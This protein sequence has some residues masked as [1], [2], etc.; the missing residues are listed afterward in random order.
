MVNASKILT[1]SYGTFSCTLEGFDEPFS[2]MKSI[3]EY[4]RDLAADDR[5]FGAEPPTPDAEMLHRIAEREIQRRVEARV[6]R[7]GILLRPAED[8]ETDDSEQSQQVDE[9]DTP[10][11]A[12]DPMVAATV[13]TSV[14]ARADM[15]PEAPDAPEA[16]ADPT[17]APAPAAAAPAPAPAAP[18]EPADPHAETVAEK[19]RRIRAA[20]ARAQTEPQ[21]ASTFAE[22]ER[23]ELSN[24]PIDGIMSAP[25]EDE[26]EDEDVPAADESA[27]D[28]EGML[29]AVAAAELG[30]VPATVATDED[31]A[32]EDTVEDTAEQASPE[33]A[34]TEQAADD[35]D[36]AD[37]AALGLEAEADVPFEFAA[38]T[39]ADV[40]DFAE[41]SSFEDETAEDTLA[42]FEMPEDDG[43]ED[44]A[45]DMTAPTDM[46]DI[47]EAFAA[48]DFEDE[49]EDIALVLPET[50]GV[51]R[52]EPVAETPADDASF[53]D[54]G[55]DIESLDLDTSA[56]ET[57]EDDADEAAF[58]ETAEDDLSD[59]D[60]GDILG[61][62]TASEPEA[63]EETAPVE[64]DTAE[65]VSEETDEA[66]DRLPP[67]SLTSA[68][69]IDETDEAEADDAPHVRVLKM[70]RDEFD[71]QYA[72][73][74]TDEDTEV[75]ELTSLD[76]D[77]EPLSERDEIRAALGETGLSEDDEADLIDELMRAGQD[78]EETPDTADIDHRDAVAA[79]LA[80]AAA[81]VQRNEDGDTTAPDTQSGDVPVDRL[82]A[83][84][85]T[86]LRNNDNKRRRSAIAHLKAAVAAVR[87]DGGRAASKREREA[88]RAMSQYR[89][90]LASAVRPTSGPALTD[91]DARSHKLRLDDATEDMGDT[92]EAEAEA[93]TP[94]PAPEPAA[95]RPSGLRR[96]T[97]SGSGDQPRRKRP[98]APL[99]LVSE[100]RI[101]REED[102]AAE[103]SARPVRPRRVRS[104][105]V[106]ASE[107]ASQ[108]DVSEDG[109]K[110]FVDRMAPDGLQELLEASA[111]FA[112]AVRG[113][114]SNSR[115]QI[116][117]RVARLLP[118][119]AFS[120]E[121]GLRAFGVLLREGRILRV[122]RG[123]FTV[124]PGS[125]FNDAQRRSAAG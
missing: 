100:Q 74:D 23:P 88:E 120:R 85:D 50:A 114:A 55:F 83:Q 122:E 40:T 37:L 64:E 76:G 101:D 80:A 47:A 21:L 39:D 19:L 98:M 68:E 115:P 60:L 110:A 38:T 24:A 62:D 90:D 1:V 16:V 119:G 51:V 8:A 113:E 103:A 9:Q 20:V 3:A 72:E 25:A 111:A 43:T 99:M 52:P 31:E 22:D 6:D 125:R 75:Q 69:R 66:D 28:D 54:E 49:A 102:D 71:A 5:Y 118:D 107:A 4:F 87:A 81:E 7:N 63:E 78:D 124:A 82:L 42:G 46:P 108:D 13:A 33:Q 41:A 106:D 15:A 112:G 32:V 91:E 77:A 56:P 73:D 109:F 105:D 10:A 18:A 17:P 45:E 79:D 35:L 96:P 116:M 93:P 84:A 30:V 94:E 58:E 29:D 97:V 95:D 57:A 92:P 12:A 26:A 104:D 117:S 14:A 67:L 86:E 53:E 11:P 121:D 2:T 36:E 59:L 27:A 61:A 123:R 89:D 34:S 65:D 70:S 44:E 48:D